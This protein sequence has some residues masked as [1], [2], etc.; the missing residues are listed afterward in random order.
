MLP[1]R[2]TGDRGKYFSCRIFFFSVKLMFITRVVFSWKQSKSC[3]LV[4]STWS[5]NADPTLPVVVP[6]CRV[7]AI[8]FNTWRQNRAGIGHP[9]RLTSEK[10]ERWHP[11]PPPT[12]H[13]PV[14]TDL[15]FLLWEG[16]SCR[17]FC[18]LQRTHPCRSWGSVLSRPTEPGGLYMVS[19]CLPPPPKRTVFRLNVGVSAFVLLVGLQFC[20]FDL[21]FP[22]FLHGI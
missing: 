22:S 16:S 19:V 4:L 11:P 1:T 21:V 3:G 15:Y 18:S 13:F 2:E 5:K 14:H 12:P 8:K 10:R 20:V 7:G 9:A 17:Y 6:F